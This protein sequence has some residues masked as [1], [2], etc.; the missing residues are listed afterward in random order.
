[1]S[2]TI[3]DSIQKIPFGLLLAIY[4]GYLGLEYHAFTTAADSKLIQSQNELVQMKKE[5]VALQA[6]LKQATDYA[7]SFDSKRAELRRMVQSLDELKG[8]LNADVDIASFM[9][10]AVT[11]AKKVGLNVLGI[12]PS[13]R[14]SHE[15]YEEQPFSL[16]FRGVYVQLLVFL[17]RLS[18]IQNVVQI[19]DFEIHPVSKGTSRYVELEGV[20]QVKTYKYVAT[21][22]DDI[23]RGGGAASAPAGAQPPK[24][25][26]GDH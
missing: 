3:K 8:T 17:E 18:N 23:G 9:K 7:K 15:F 1:M 6:K 24:S 21:A 2:D 22:A 20:V 26:E 16:G 13:A 11:E 25:K 19:D 12:K 5:N 4:L 14:K 10:T